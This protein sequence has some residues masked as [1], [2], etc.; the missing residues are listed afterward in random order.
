MQGCTIE[1]KLFKKRKSL[2]FFIPVSIVWAYSSPYFASD[3][4]AI[5]WSFNTFVNLSLIIHC[6]FNPFLLIIHNRKLTL[7]NIVRLL[8][9]SNLLIMYEMT[10]SYG[11]HEYVKRTTDYLTSNNMLYRQLTKYRFKIR[12]QI[13]WKQTYNDRKYM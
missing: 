3:L 2:Y 1:A 4:M 13:L 6:S 8:L 7:Y 11:F 12:R 10:I 5:N 9:Y